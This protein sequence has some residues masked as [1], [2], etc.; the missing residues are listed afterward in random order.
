MKSNGVKALQL[1][2]VA[3]TASI[4]LG[5]A[6]ASVGSAASPNA[7]K[8]SDQVVADLFALQTADAAS[9]DYFL[10]IDGIDGESK[11]KGHEGEIEVMS[12]SWGVSNSGSAATGG[13]A[14]AGKA[15]FS[16]ISITKVLDKAS[17]QLFTAVATGK[18]IPTVTFKAVADSGKDGKQEYYVVKLTDVLISSFQQAGASGGDR[19]TESVSLNYAKI[20]IEYKT[21]NPDGSFGESVKASWD[22][23]KNVK[24]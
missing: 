3:V 18:H 12:W 10:K 22:L 4:I 19:P 5:Y 6:F 11:V 8:S 14:G 7:Q 24:A 13:G 23:A 9:V 21:Q 2:A 16:D 1:A 20:E 17:P 15:S